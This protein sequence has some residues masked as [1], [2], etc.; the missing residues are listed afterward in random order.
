MFGLLEFDRRRRY[1][2]G[3][4]LVAHGLLLAWMLHSPKPI[5]VAPSAI[6][7]GQNGEAI[8]T[9][10]WQPNGSS[11]DA[12]T[13]ERLVLPKPEPTRK[14]DRENDSDKSYRE[15]QSSSTANVSTG[16][17]AGSPFGSLS[18]GA[19]VGWEVRPAL[20]LSGA[21]PQVDADDLHGEAGIEII[22][23]TID[24]VGNIT[25]KVVITSLSPAVDAKVMAALS[26]WHFHPATK[27]GVPIPS[28]QDVYY[29]FPVRR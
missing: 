10:Y 25:D 5:F 24:E 4:S 27:N 8:T 13:H 18:Y 7:Q 17:P 15:T 3:V 19:V 6:A 1:A 16:A 21:E 22:E 29:N 2:P 20:R 26:T 12:T 23:I 14:R 28:K 9:L 11:I